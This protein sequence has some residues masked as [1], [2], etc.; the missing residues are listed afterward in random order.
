MK[1]R[2][3]YEVLYKKKTGAQAA[4]WHPRLTRNEFK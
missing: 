2:L 4:D 1:G 3:P